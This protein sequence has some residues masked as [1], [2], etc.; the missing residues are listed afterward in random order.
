MLELLLLELLLLESVRL[1][2]L[3]APILLEL[4]LLETTGVVSWICY[5]WSRVNKSCLLELPSVL[6]AGA[7][8]TEC[9]L[10]ELEEW[11]RRSVVCDDRDDWSDV[12]RPQEPRNL[13][14]EP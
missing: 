3:L 6:P 4:L 2:L 5:Y 14:E 11:K 7:E 8:T 10:R 13:S 12:Y 1:E 9:C